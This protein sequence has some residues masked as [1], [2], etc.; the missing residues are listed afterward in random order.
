MADS[1]DD[2]AQRRR[3]RGFGRHLLG[4]FAVAAALVAAN[5]WLSPGQPWAFLPVVAWGAP[6]AIHAAY[7]MGL[8]DEISAAVAR[9]RK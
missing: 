5:V 7:A 6:L 9:R 1:D 2:A 3:L 8:L 4:Y